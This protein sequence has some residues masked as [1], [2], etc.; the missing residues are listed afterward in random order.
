VVECPVDELNRPS[1]GWRLNVRVPPSDAE[2]QRLFDGWRDD[3]AGARKFMPSA[4]NYTAAR[5]WS[6]V[7]LRIGETS[8]LDLLDVKWEL[9][10]FGK[11]HV[12]FG[13]GSRRRGYKQRMASLING[14]RDVLTWYVEDV[15]GMFDDAWE[16][17]GAPLLPSE[18]KGPDGACGRASREALRVGLDEAVTR[19]LPAWHGRLTPHVLRHFCASSLYRDGLD[20]VA[21]QELL[22][23]EWIATT[24]GYVH[25]HR[26]H[27]D[28]AWNTAAKRS[29]VRLDGAKR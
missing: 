7:G 19:H 15:R 22:G 25:V 1:G 14:S 26:T 29:A 27:V 12:R 20:L 10:A 21:I 2:L 18:R 9:G 11:L 6:L 17:P 5:L 3:L 8:K 28:D 23:H 16:R 13:K 24:M 4:R